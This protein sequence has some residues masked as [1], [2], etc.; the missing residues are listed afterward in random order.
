[1]KPTTYYVEY[2]GQL[3]GAWHYKDFALLREAKRFAC[4][5]TGFAR[6]FKREDIRDV[7]PNGDPAGSLW[8][9]NEYDI[10]ENS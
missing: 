7:T 6:V 1:M 8:D 4:D 10:Y 5:Q 2:E 3:E 9:C